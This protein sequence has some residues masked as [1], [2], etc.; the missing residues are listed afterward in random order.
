MQHLSTVCCVCV[1]RNPYLLYFLKSRGLKVE[2]QLVCAILVS[3][4]AVRW[5]PPLSSTLS[6]WGRSR[7]MHMMSLFAVLPALWPEPSAATLTPTLVYFC[8]GSQWQHEWS[9]LRPD[10]ILLSLQLCFVMFQTDD[11][12]GP[13]WNWLYFI[14]LIIIGSFFVLNLVLGVLSGYVHCFVHV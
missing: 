5:I 4:V 12:L 14:P 9:L 7:S 13:S 8:L 11:A 6:L 2:M 10:L 3:S 1:H